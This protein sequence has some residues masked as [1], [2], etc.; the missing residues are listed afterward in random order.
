MSTA[1]SCESETAGAERVAADA[2][3]TAIGTLVEAI[4]LQ[5]APQLN[6]LY[7]RVMGYTA[8]TAR[9]EVYFPAPYGQKSVK[10]RNLRPVTEDEANEVAACRAILTKKGLSGRQTIDLC[11]EVEAM[12]QSKA[13]QLVVKRAML[14]HVSAIRSRLEE[15]AGPSSSRDVGALMA[16]FLPLVADVLPRDSGGAAVVP[17]PHAIVKKQA[18]THI[19][20]SPGGQPVFETMRV[21]D[22][23]NTQITTRD[24]YTCNNRCDWD[25][26]LECWQQMEALF[27]NTD[28]DHLMWAVEVTGLAV[29]PLPWLLEAAA[30]KE[31]VEALARDWPLALFERLVR[32][33]VDVANS[34]VVHVED[35]RNVQGD[36]GFWQAVALVQLL[37]QANIL[38]AAEPRVDEAGVKGP[39]MALEAFTLEAIDK[40]DDISE[41]NRWK[42]YQDEDITEMIMRGDLDL[43]PAFCAFLSH[44]SLVPITFRRRCLIQD[45]FYSN[46]MRTTDAPEPSALP[47]RLS[48]NVRR[49]VAELRDDVLRGLEGVT[50]GTLGI[51]LVARFDG[52]PASGPGVTTEFFQLAL[53]AFLE[54]PVWCFDEQ[55]RCYWF[56]ETSAAAEGGDFEAQRGRE[57]YACGV[58]LGQG[59]LS[60]VFVPKVFPRC[61][62]ALLL[63]NLGSLQYQAPGLSELAVVAPE[64]AKSLERLLEHDGDDLDDMY[65]CLSWPSRPDGPLTHGNKR[66]FVALYVDWFFTGRFA[67]QL[68]PFCTGFRE[69]MGRSGLL[70]RLFDAAQLENVVCGG[71]VPV[72]VAA[73]RAASVEDGWNGEGDSAYLEGFWEALAALGDADR[74]RFLLFTTASD[75]MPL[76][77]WGALRIFVQ[78]N[79]GGDERLPTSLTCFNTLLLPRYT[80]TERLRTCLQQ[81]IKNSQGFGLE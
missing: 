75:R 67:E 44:S 10:L 4:G 26:C 1:V 36:V 22:Q 14:S 40:C 43:T 15:H 74:G 34:K 69:V 80:S 35:S 23:C 71:D 38:D 64:L 21:C 18:G 12:C 62:Y 32:A 25:L 39:R 7:G 68:K 30:R 54:S 29:A 59:L 24:Y 70:R 49:G 65:G 28:R 17:H 57:L 45:A 60:D 78:K 72:D 55:H 19:G 58:L 52:E 48:L 51:P 81:A 16:Q 3:V 77:G 42:E 9:V 63:R 66:D 61:L 6:G 37:Y 79:G 73:I 53:Q 5:S 56:A 31:L 41:F 27:Q 8:D 33:I 11:G 76:R 2:V 50:D 47:T 20:F 46:L 13:G